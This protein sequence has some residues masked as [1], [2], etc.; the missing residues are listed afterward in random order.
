MAT[1]RY[2]G[3]TNVFVPSATAQVV[4]FIV[5]D[6]K[7]KIR[8][9]TQWFGS[10]SAD[11]TTGVEKPIAGYWILD[12]DEPVRVGP[13]I[14]PSSNPDPQGTGPSVDNEDLWHP[15]NNRPDAN[16]AV[17]FKFIT[18]QMDRRNYGYQLD[19][20][21]RDVA[22]LPIMEIYRK[23]ALSKAM[24]KKTWR[25]IKTLENS[26]NWPST[27]T[28]DANTLNGGQGTWAT[29]SSDEN[30]ANRYAIRNAVANAC[31]QVAL[32]TNDV[33]GPEDLKM[34][35]SPNVARTLANTGEIYGYLKSSPDA[36]GR[37]GGEG[38]LKERFGFPRY[39]AGVEWII[40]SAVAVTEERNA[41]GTAATTNRVFIK[42]DT[43]AV[44]VARPGSVAGVPGAPSFSTIQVWYYKYEMAV[45][46]EFDS[47][48][49]QYKGAVVDQYAEVLAAPRAGYLITNIL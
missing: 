40:E 46:E 19:S 27:N 38:E 28:A 42:N 4:G 18:A 34:I 49:L 35:I 8:E 3:P 24:R 45:H 47:W 6:K 25:V 16:V 11:T 9:Y 37:Q 20:Q 12:P 30:S 23:T 13:V 43:T 7:F 15:G 17:N 21:T 1:P 39:Y 36:L 26:A 5:D 14:T 44:L 33:V 32:Q 29:A 2:A 48:N 41:A 10:E 31:V 22:D